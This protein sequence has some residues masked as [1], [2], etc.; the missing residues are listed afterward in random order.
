MPVITGD[1]YR[2][3]V[4]PGRTDFKGTYGNGAIPY[5]GTCQDV[6]LILTCN[7]Q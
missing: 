6:P 2:P 1:Q 4:N 7:A 3:D 5:T